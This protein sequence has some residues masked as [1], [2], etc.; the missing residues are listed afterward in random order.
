MVEDGMLSR[1]LHIPIQEILQAQ[2]DET[3]RLARELRK[4]DS[5]VRTPPPA[6]SCATCRHEP[7]VDRAECNACA[8][9]W[10]DSRYTEHI[11]WESKESKPRFDGGNWPV[12]DSLMTLAA[13]A[14]FIE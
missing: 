11:G 9:W 8:R 10:N 5:N 1:T 4:R 2:I 6:R 12:R 14:F 13:Q 7:A 3:A